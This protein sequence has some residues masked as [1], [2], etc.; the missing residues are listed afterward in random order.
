MVVRA[1]S[2]PIPVPTERAVINIDDPR[3][4]W[5][6]EHGSLHIPDVQRSRTTSQ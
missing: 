1:H 5:M 2:G 4:S 6:R 3:L